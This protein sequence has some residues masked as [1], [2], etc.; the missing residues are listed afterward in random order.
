MI[1]PNDDRSNARPDL[2]Q[3]GTNARGT[4]TSQKVDP[5]D[6]AG[7]SISVIQ[8][9]SMET[10]LSAV[11]L[12]K[13]LR[14][15][16]MLAL[17]VGLL[18]AILAASAAWTLL[19]P[20]SYQARAL[21]MASSIPPRIIFQT[22]ESWINFETY[23]RNQLT[24][25]KSR[26]VLNAALR[27]PRVAKYKIGEREEDPIAWLESKIQAN[28][29]GEIFHISMN[30]Q[31]PEETADLVNS[32]KDAYLKDVVYAEFELRR[33]RQEHLKTLYSKLQTDL[34]DDRLELQALAEQLGS[35]D[36]ETNRLT[37]ELAIQRRA[38]REREVD[39]L[40]NDILKLE[41]ELS[42]RRQR[43]QSAKDQVVIPDSM[44]EQ[45]VEQ[46]EGVQKFLE[47]IESLETAY[48]R[49]ARVAKDPRD[50]S[51]RYPQKQLAQLRA[52]LEARRQ[53]LRPWVTEQLRK[54]AVATLETD[55]AMLEDRLAILR[56][57]EKQLMT[58]VESLSVESKSIGQQTMSLQ[59]L[60]DEI[61][62]ADTAAKK[63]GDELANLDVEL[64]E[65]P[66][67]V[68]EREEATAPRL[69]ADKRPKMAG[70]AGMGTFA[71]VLLLISWNE[72]RARKIDSVDELVHSLGLTVVGTVPSLNDRRMR[73]RSIGSEGSPARNES[74]LLVESIDAARTYMLHAARIAGIRVVMVTSACSGEGK[75]SLACHLAA[76][77]ARAGRRTL[78]IDGD[79]RKPMVHN[80]FDLV[81]APGLSEL[82][83]RE[84]EFDQAVQPAP[85]PGLWVIS[86][87]QSDAY[88][89]QALAHEDAQA[90]FQR[91]RELYDFVL[92][93]SSPVLAVADAL[94]IGQHADVAI[95][96]VLRDVSRVPKVQA[97][98]LRL[99]SLGIRIL[100]A[101]MTGV[102]GDQY[103]G[104]Y[105]Q[106][107]ATQTEAVTTQA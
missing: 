4:L 60:Q 45:Y 85:A 53:M 43:S 49:A 61:E 63:I 15:R 90:I 7:Q 67:R 48:N 22:N 20:P 5:M 2:P 59:S 31:N 25:I 97:A 44:V 37:H 46:D 40:R 9:R 3:L 50:P 58:V 1:P 87:G 36:R 27:D 41:A 34:N 106:N 11:A 80:L 77:L 26:T 91:A 71:L 79:L 42:V 24:L 30:G 52:D 81:P 103:G 17:N 33:K 101:V 21:L 51:R 96:S 68:V 76:S 73:R 88:A 62:H 14:R 99:Q 86:A 12:L 56:E 104:M 70:M 18:C 64:F 89:I 38:D 35:D 66:P 39:T 65:A 19:P 57:Q 10:K 29:D 94:L 105:Y 100:G 72:Y 107:G 16:W 74:G 82:L 32:V 54:R 92:I 98:K 55:V 23:K 6:H 28:F 83:R 102:T 8:P 13:A 47:T 78:L 95:C 84:I 75:T 69:E 93:D